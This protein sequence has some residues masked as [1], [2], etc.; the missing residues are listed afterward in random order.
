MIN[1]TNEIKEYKKR[2]GITPENFEIEDY[3][4]LEEVRRKSDEEVMV[5]IIYR[6]EYFDLVWDIKE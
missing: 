4:V 5:Y 3:M 6:G 2:G 1:N